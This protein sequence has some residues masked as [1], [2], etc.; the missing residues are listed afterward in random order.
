MVGMGQKKGFIVKGLEQVP[1]TPVSMVQTP[2]D[3]DLPQTLE[4]GANMA[5]SYSCL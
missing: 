2:P 4:H 3:F 5:A 1:T